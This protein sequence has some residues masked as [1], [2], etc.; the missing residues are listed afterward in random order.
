MCLDGIVSP[1]RLRWVKCVFVFIWNLPPVLLAEWPGSFICH[2]SNTGMERTSNNLTGTESSLW[3]RKYSH[4]SCRGS[5]PISF[6]HESV[7]LPSAS[8]PDSKGRYCFLYQ[9][10]NDTTVSVCDNFIG[11]G[12]SGCVP[13][14]SKCVVLSATKFKVLALASRTE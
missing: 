5:N 14:T 11:L 13:R 4:R 2:C 8:Y 3:R 10:E 1:L 9:R 7:A 12:L 6:D